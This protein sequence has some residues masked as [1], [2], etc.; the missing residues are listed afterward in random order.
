[1][2]QGYFKNI[3][4]DD[5]YIINNMCKQIEGDKIFCVC[6]GKRFKILSR[7]SSQ[8]TYDYTYNFIRFGFATKARN[9]DF[10]AKQHPYCPNQY[11][12]QI[13]ANFINTAVELGYYTRTTDKGFNGGNQV[14]TIW[15]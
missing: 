2:A 8:Y 3:T 7:E 15:M 6:T 4:E 12:A 14:Q 13:I 1:M 10:H 11:M 5:K 9:T